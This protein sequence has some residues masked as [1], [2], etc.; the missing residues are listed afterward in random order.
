MGRQ[1]RAENKSLGMMGLG[2]LLS[3]KKNQGVCQ[4]MELGVFF[5]W[6]WLNQFFCGSRTEAPVS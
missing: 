5:K 3:H 1:D 4:T 2:P 6:W